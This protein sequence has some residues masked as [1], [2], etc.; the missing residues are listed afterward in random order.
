[1]INSRVD[2]ALA[3]G[4][5]GVH[6]RSSDIGAGEARAIVACASHGQRSLSPERFLIS[7]SCHTAAEVRLAEAHGADIVLF[8]PVF[9]KL[10]SSTA[11][12]GIAGLRAV[13]RDGKAARPPV[14]VLAL[15]GVTLRNAESCVRAGARGIAGIRL[16]QEGDLRATVEKLRALE[17]LERS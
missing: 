5:D 8:G 4:A 3:T 14:A 6:L 12:H 2:V 17:R 1:L 11:P 15:G 16:F 7:A 10:D 13:C 9:E